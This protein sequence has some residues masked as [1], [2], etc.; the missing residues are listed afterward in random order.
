MCKEQ[1]R[2]MQNKTQKLLEMTN[3]SIQL[4]KNMLGTYFNG[5]YTHAICLQAVIT[6]QVV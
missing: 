2:D 5:V 1:V 6:I 4:M 3:A